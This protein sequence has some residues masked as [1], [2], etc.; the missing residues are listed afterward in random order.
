MQ[1]TGP[2]TVFTRSPES[3]ERIP[4]RFTIRTEYTAYC[5]SCGDQLNAEATGIRYGVA[6]CWACF[7]LTDD[8][9]LRIALMIICERRPQYFSFPKGVIFYTP[10]LDNP[11][12]YPSLV[13]RLNGGDGRTLIP[14]YGNTW[15]RWIPPHA[16]VIIYAIQHHLLHPD[17]LI[18]NEIALH[19]P[20]DGNSLQVLHH[21][22]R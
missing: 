19:R 7:N 5:P 9:P 13:D 3:T 22:T 18:S 14:E 16:D 21:G 17:V 11:G 20:P 10:K 6:W 4:F 1:A 15:P 8:Y 12:S 2:T